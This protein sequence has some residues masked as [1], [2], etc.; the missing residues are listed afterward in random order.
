MNRKK[1]L[2]HDGEYYR[3]PLVGM[4]THGPHVMGLDN[5]LVCISSAIEGLYKHL[6]LEIAVAPKKEEK[7]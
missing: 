1:C 4:H 5:A 2:I 6:G 3:V 7:K